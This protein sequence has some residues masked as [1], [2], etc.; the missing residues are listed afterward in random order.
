MHARPHRRPGAP[1]EDRGRLRR[2]AARRSRACA[3]CATRTI[4]DG[5]SRDALE[6]DGRAR[7]GRDP[8]PGGASA[9]SGWASPSSRSC[10]RSSAARSRRSRSSRAVAARGPG[11]R[12][13]AAATRRSSAGSAPLDRAAR[14]VLALAQQERA[15]AT[16]CAA[17]RRAPSARGARLAPVTARRSQVLDGALAPTRSSS[18]RAH[19]RRRGRRAAASR[20][21]SCRATPPG[22]R[23]RAPVARRL[24][25]RRA[26][27]A[28]RREVGG[29]R[30]RRRAGRGRA[31]C[32]SASSIAPRS[33][34]APRCSAA[35]SR[36]SSA[37]SLPEEAHAVRRADR[38]LPG[39]QAPRGA[40]VH[41]DRAGA[42][43]GDGRGARARRGQ[44]RSAAQLVSLA[45]ARCSD[46][47]SWSRTRPCRCT[48]ASA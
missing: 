8:V 23:D 9:A 10:S 16:T 22:L 28:R 1:R 25:Q 40:A 19:G 21:S 24:A 30:A 4:R 31:R 5:F 27:A 43:G 29:R 2:R 37:R 11:A 13:A 7:L 44:R 42:L 34:S 32:S 38:Q 20:S 36:P 18:S 35:M 12:C 3:R 17:S 15:A 14:S 41:R 33:A 6:A 47:A 48:A 45:K 46:A 26:R 39:A